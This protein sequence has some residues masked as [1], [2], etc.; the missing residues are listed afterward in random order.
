MVLNISEAVGETILENYGICVMTC[1]DCFKQRLDITFEAYC[2]NADKRLQK[3]MKTFGGR[4]LLFDNIAEDET[5]IDNQLEQL[6]KM[7]RKISRSSKISIRN[8][9]FLNANALTGP[10]LK[11]YPY[12]QEDMK[13]LYSL[14]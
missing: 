13:R 5:T 14:L 11:Q 4:V 3:L 9:A 10:R 12:L 2:K 1:G 8:E 6:I 7:T